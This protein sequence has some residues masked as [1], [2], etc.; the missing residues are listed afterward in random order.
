MDRRSGIIHPL[1]SRGDGPNIVV[2]RVVEKTNQEQRT[3]PSEY[4]TEKGQAD[5]MPRAISSGD[6]TGSTGST[7]YRSA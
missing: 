1:F 6:I 2:Q 4:L 5:P 3:H 7:R